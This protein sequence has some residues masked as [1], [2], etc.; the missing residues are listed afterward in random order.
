MISN[1]P[2]CLKDTRSQALSSV[3]MQ[4]NFIG[5]V[6]GAIELTDSTGKDLGREIKREGTEKREYIHVLVDRRRGPC[7]FVFI[8]SHRIG[9][10][11]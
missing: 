2:D 5:R 9:W 10:Y 7:V 1:H 4:S 3:V 8:C 6:K 11:L